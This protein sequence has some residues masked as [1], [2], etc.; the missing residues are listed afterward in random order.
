MLSQLEIFCWMKK[1]LNMKNWKKKVCWEKLFQ[2][3]IDFQ[4]KSCDDQVYDNNSN[5][6]CQVETSHIV[7]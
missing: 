2:T 5:K 6:K 3:K 1:T 4:L 7:D